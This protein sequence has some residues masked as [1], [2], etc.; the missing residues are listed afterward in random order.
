MPYRTRTAA[1]TTP[2]P[3]E[4]PPRSHCHISQPPPISHRPARTKSTTERVTVMPRFRAEPLRRCK[5]V[6]RRP[7][8]LRAAC[9]ASMGPLVTLARA[10]RPVLA[11]ALLV[12]VQTAYTNPAVVAA[13]LRAMSC[14]GHCPHPASLPSARSCCGV[15]AVTSGPA[16]V[17]ASRTA[18]PLGPTA[19][20][21]AVVG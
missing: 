1:P 2:Q 19:L 8:R 9:P 6:M 15:T 17:S 5:R 4:R 21:L 12:G 20:L 16:T 7:R 13:E 11:L 14:C 3:A 10:A 18:A